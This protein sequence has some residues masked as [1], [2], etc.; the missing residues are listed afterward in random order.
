MRTPESH[1]RAGICQKLSRAYPHFP[2]LLRAENIFVYI[3]PSLS[4]SALYIFF[5]F[6]S[7]RFDS[8][9]SQKCISSSSII[10]PENDISPLAIG[11]TKYR[12]SKS[13]KKK[14]KILLLLLGRGGGG[15]SARLNKIEYRAGWWKLFAETIA[16][17]W[18]RDIQYLAVVVVSLRRF[19]VRV[20]IVSRAR[21]YIYYVYLNAS[22]RSIIPEIETSLY[23]STSDENME[24]CGTHTHTHSLGLP[25]RQWLRT[26][27]RVWCRSRGR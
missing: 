4:L 9:Y 2:S 26:C 3:Y 5:R 23:I 8:F 21:V 20:Q 6:N 19:D 17:A 16:R 12:D 24:H 22:A 27:V 14:L 10:Y 13:E 15:L 18:R 1:R 7:R 25:A 11:E